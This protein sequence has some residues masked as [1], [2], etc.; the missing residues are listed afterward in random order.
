MKI[1]DMVSRMRHMRSDDLL[2]LAGLQR[3]R[4]AASQIGPALGLFG[5]GLLLGAGLG[6]LFAPRSGH[7]L[8]HDMKERT[9]GRLRAVREKT[10]ETG[11]GGAWAAGQSGGG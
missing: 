11:D 3:R 9:I 4:S 2:H 10:K 1:K 5:A 7:E 8:R 6:L